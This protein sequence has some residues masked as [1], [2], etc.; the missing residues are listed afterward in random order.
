MRKFKLVLL[1]TNDP[2]GLFNGAFGFL[3]HSLIDKVRDRLD[4]RHIYAYSNDKIK[5]GDY[6]Y[7]SSGYISK[8]LGFNLDAIKLEDGQRWTKDC[9]KIIASSNKTLDGLLLIHDK[10]I[11]TYVEKYNKNKIITKI[12]LIE[13]DSIFVKI[14][15]F[16][17]KKLKTKF[18]REE[19]RVNLMWAL[20]EFAAEKGLTPS[21]LEMKEVNLWSDKW[22]K[23]NV[24]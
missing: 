1:P 11:A 4:G 21:S 19:M 15:K 6:V 23:K 24:L 8:V 14:I 9:K 5:E 2:T 3:H 17:T 16:K 20:S 22:F 13:D 18:T 12:S 7:H 10:S